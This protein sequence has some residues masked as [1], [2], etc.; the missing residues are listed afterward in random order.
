MKETY[1]HEFN[2]WQRMAARVLGM[3]RIN[4]DSIDFR[5]GYFAPRFGFELTIQQGGYFSS[6][7]AVNVCLGWG[8][9]HVRLPF[10]MK[11]DPGCEWGTYGISVHSQTFWVY[12]GWGHPAGWDLPLATWVFDSHEI[13]NVNGEYESVPS[14]TK[15]WEMRELD[16]TLK[17][18]FPFV[19]I[20]KNG[21]VQERTATVTQERRTWHRKWFPFSKMVIEVIEVEFSGEVGE[22]SGSWKGGV[23]GTSY[24][25]KPTE[26]REQTFERMLQER[27]F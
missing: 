22:R 8:A 26:T 23:T 7:Y 13:M 17:E 4:T 9:F 20:L 15:A 11:R 24:K 2:F 1:S 6:N 19:Y 3:W 10:H 27:E 16:T 21:T 5:W 14:K 18:T 25:M 12:R